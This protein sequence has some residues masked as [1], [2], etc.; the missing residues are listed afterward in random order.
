MASYPPAMP[1]RP[2]LIG[3]G[4]A[5]I[6]LALAW[7][8]MLLFGG[9]E[10]DRG[11]LML[12]YAGERP[13][14]ATYA[15]WVTEFGGWRVLLPATVLGIVIL[16][17]RRRFRAAIVL[18][19]LTASGRALVELQKM[20]TARI[21]PEEHEHLVEVQSLSFPSGH[22]ADSAIVW[23]A[24]AFLLIDRYPARAFAVWAAAWL[25]LA[26]GISRLVL[27]VHWPTDVIGGWA[28]GIFWTLL[29]LT[30]AGFPLD[31]GTPSQ[32]RH[33]S[34]EGDAHEQR[35]QPWSGARPDGE[36]P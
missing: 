32:L 35:E 31:D 5:L 10:M 11:F 29:L 13:E 14:I 8:V 1:R 36:A 2:G 28:F 19:L 21:R 7:S 25:S 20:Q 27:G 15:R 12:L 16:L 4:F 22:A 30:L 24:L 33:S 23:L 34:P 3:I 17:V 9:T 6:G 18:F 26:V